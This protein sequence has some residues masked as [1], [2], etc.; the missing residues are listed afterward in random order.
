LRKKMCS[1]FQEGYCIACRDRGLSVAGGRGLQVSCWNRLRLPSSEVPMSALKGPSMPGKTAL[2]LIIVT[3][4]SAAS[5]RAQ[6][7]PQTSEVAPPEADG[8]RFR[9]GINATAG[10]ESVSGSSVGSSTV[11]G[12]MFGLDLRLGWQFSNLLA[13]YAQ[14]HLSFGSLSTSQ[15][16]ASYSG[17]T[18][19]IVGTIMG[20]LTFMDRFFAGAG[21]GYGMFNNPS[22]FALDFKAGGYPLMGHGS[23]GIRRKGLMVGLDFRPVFLSGATG[24]L[25]MGC[26]GYE[27]F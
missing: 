13:I 24:L 10:L 16:N 4:L 27:S 21:F 17:F 26:I 12:G 1:I 15:G 5:A 2:T 6:E 25:V 3:L 11:S 9:F 18:G 20:E 19:T 23:N 14:P 22:G 7:V 8:G